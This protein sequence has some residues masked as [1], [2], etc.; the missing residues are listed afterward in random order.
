MEM[1]QQ[2]IL[3]LKE[4][5]DKETHRL[6]TCSFYALTFLAHMIR[7]NQLVKGICFGNTEIKQVLYADDITLFIK[8]I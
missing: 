7:N 4:E 3:R 2:V 1:H 5:L 8:D 6:H